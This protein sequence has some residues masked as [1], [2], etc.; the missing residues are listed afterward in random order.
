MSSRIV[1]GIRPTGHPQ[2]GNYFGA[3]KQWVSIAE[4]AD[5][6]FFC[7][8]DQH[9]LTT[10]KDMQTLKQ[11]TM[12]MA[13]TY[14]ACG[15]DP[16]K[17]AIFVQS[18]VPYHTE[19]AW[20]LTCITP[21]GWLSRMT[22]FKDKAGK[23]RENALTGLFTYPVLMAADIVLYGA[24]H[25]PV[26]DDQKQHVEFA[27]DI[28]QV[29]N[30][31]AEAAILKMPE[32]VIQKSGAR[33]KS[34]RDGLKK[35]SKSD[36][37]DYSRINLND[38]ND[39]IALKIKKA[40]TDPDAITGDIKSLENRPELENLITLHALLEDKPAQTVLASFDGKNFSDLKL[41][42]TDLLIAHLSPI[43]EQVNTLLN[44]QAYLNTCL[45]DGAARANTVAQQTM[46]QVRSSLNLLQ[47]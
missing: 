21:M 44:D 23:K 47:L 32:P 9:A 14:I 29:F 15:I 42:L 4:K 17:N 16:V 27:R 45:K 6:T 43:R 26:G 11:D 46:Q 20:Y 8:V 38:D 3:L 25:V 13:A 5:E 28:V 1:S 30:N 33:I 36:V 7:I 12:I 39:L 37:S 10:L 24:T 40:K 35:M 19:L 18:H 2:L 34:L 31:M 22:Q 41:S